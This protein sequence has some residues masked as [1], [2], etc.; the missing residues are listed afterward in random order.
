MI[1]KPLDATTRSLPSP[2]RTD[3]SSEVTL[4]LVARNHRYT[5][6]LR[7]WGTD[8]DPDLVTKETGLVPCRTWLRGS[9]RG[10]RVYEASMWGFNGWGQEPEQDWDS[11]EDGLTFVQGTED[12]F[13]RLTEPYTVGWWCGHFQSSFDGGP[14][15][16]AE[17]LARLGAFGASLYIDN[18]FSRLWDERNDSESS[19][20]TDRSS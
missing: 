12:I 4:I 20:G 8:L 15:L 9:Q 10:N 6:E 19:G 18:Y 2:V 14:E 11:L 16:S 13:K 1:S 17:L 7:V 5:V 3:V